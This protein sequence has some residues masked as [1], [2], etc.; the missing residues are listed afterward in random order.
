MEII[1]LARPAGPPPKKAQEIQT[2]RWLNEAFGQD[3]EGQ[4]WETAFSALLS[5]EV[6][7]SQVN[8]PGSATDSSNCAECAHTY[9]HTYS[10]A[11]KTVQDS[12]N[13]V[14][15]RVMSEDEMREKLGLTSFGKRRR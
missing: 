12:L 15:L 9:T 11:P 10:N 6:R 14:Q 8:V 2:L 1:S 7:A 4:E 5:G 3:K 13:I